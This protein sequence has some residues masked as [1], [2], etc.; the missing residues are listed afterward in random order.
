MAQIL[1][2]IVKA[3]SGPCPL[4]ETLI[5]NTCGV[6]ILGSNLLFIVIIHLGYVNILGFI[7]SVFF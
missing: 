1:S 5:L 2:N 4:L 3:T 6:T 7:T